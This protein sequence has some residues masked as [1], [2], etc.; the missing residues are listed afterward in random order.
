M[1][2]RRYWIAALL[3]ASVWL[4]W[5]LAP[6]LGLVDVEERCREWVKSS[7]FNTAFLRRDAYAICLVKMTDEK[8]QAGILGFGIL[9]GAGALYVV[10]KGILK[11]D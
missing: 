3:I 4:L 2:S 1:T 11:K 10:L 8:A 7:P 9:G 5:N 6:V